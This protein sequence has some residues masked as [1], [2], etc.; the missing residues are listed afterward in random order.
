MNSIFFSFP[1]LASFVS[2]DINIFKT[3]FSLVSFEFKTN[4]KFFTVFLF[5]KQF[6]SIITKL[7]TSIIFITQ[8]AGYQSVIPTFIGKVFGV[9]NYII[10]G[11]TD[12]N[13]LPSISYGNYNKKLLRWATEYS[14][15]NAFHLIPVNRELIECE[16]TYT[17]LDFKKQGYKSFIKNINTPYTIIPNGIDLDLYNITNQIREN[18]SFI[19]IC[20]VLVDEKRRLVKGIDLL[21][22]IA[23]LIPEMNIT[24]IGGTFPSDM[25]IPSNIQTLPFIENDGLPEIFNKNQFYLQL[26]LTEGFPNAVIEAMACGCVP[27]VSSVGAMP[28]IVQEFGYILPKKDIELLQAIIMKA[29]KEYNK[30]KPL[31]VRTRAENFDINYRKERLLNLLKEHCS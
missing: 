29:M 2:K 28:D 15:K 24:I 11:G 13:W 31:K 20:S 30:H 26:S 16:Y 10:L 12:C 8:F 25:S 14:L 9:K 19:T 27:I 17:E 4:Y 21:L 23:A 6:V 18:N 3:K 1:S 5:L 22:E 7:N